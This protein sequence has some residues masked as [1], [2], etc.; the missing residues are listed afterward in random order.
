MVRVRPPGLGVKGGPQL[1][2][3]IAKGPPP[4]VS[5]HVALCSPQNS[6]SPLVGGVPLGGSGTSGGATSAAYCFISVA[7]LGGHS[8]RY[9]LT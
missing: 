5:T 6:S 4:D 3:P 9:L 8:G 7:R 2:I 1:R